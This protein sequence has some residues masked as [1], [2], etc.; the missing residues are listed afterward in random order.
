MRFAEWFVSSEWPR[1]F[2]ILA[3]VL[4]VLWIA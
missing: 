4:V 3:V 2:I 1:V